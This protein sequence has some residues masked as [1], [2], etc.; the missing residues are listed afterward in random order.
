M[1]V[2]Q[3][4][5]GSRVRKR[6]VRRLWDAESMVQVNAMASARPSVFLLFSVDTRRATSPR[7]V[8]FVV[9]SGLVLFSRRAPEADGIAARTSFWRENERKSLR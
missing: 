4:R 6:S 7:N 3:R 2:C 9:L 1:V 5:E 8:F